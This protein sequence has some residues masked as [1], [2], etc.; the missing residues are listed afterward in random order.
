MASC[1]QHRIYRP[2]LHSDFMY[3]L[4]GPAKEFYACIKILHNMSNSTIKE[5]KLNNTSSY[6]SVIE[7][8]EETLGIKKRRAFMDILLEFAKENPEFTDEEIRKEVD[9]FMFAG[10]DTTASAL[11]FILYILGHHP[12]IQVRI[13]EELD[14]IF[15]SGDRP[16]TAEDIRQLKYTEMCIK[17]ALRIFPPVPVVSRKVKEDVVI[18]KYHIPAGTTVGVVIYKL[19]RDPTQFPDPEVFDPDRFLPENINKRHPYA[20]VPFSAGPRNCIGQKFAMMEL[21]ILVS[22]ILRRFRVESVVPRDQL[23]LVAQVVLRL[24]NGNFVKLFPRTK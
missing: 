16:F 23:K 24:I 14:D 5:R 17:E 18:D 2:W 13:Q 19:H 3:K 12:D 8:E 10:H 1:I 22:S 15:G 4:L 20:Y 9:T 7:E 11:N 6:K 21:K